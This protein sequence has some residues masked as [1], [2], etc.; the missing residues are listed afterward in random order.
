MASYI[1]EQVRGTSVVGVEVRVLQS[2]GGW[3]VVKFEEKV[4]WPQVL[5][6][7]AK[8]KVAETSLGTAISDLASKV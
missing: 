7:L 5:V 3:V 4:V 1:Q 8:R 2:A 6:V